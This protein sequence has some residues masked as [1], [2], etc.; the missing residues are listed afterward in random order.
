MSLVNVT[1]CDWLVYKCYVNAPGNASVR[2]MR[3]I[4]QPACKQLYLLLQIYPAACYHRLPFHLDSHSR[5]QYDC[6][7]YIY[8]G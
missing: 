4:K 3:E 2:G 5:V 7:K 8:V 1:A 6:E